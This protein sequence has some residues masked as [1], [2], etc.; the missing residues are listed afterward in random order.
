M[1]PRPPRRL[2]VEYLENPLGVDRRAPRFSWVDEHAGRAQSQTA[3]QILVCSSQDLYAARRGDLWDSGK[4]MSDATAHIE[5]RGA[6]LRSHRR[7]S[8]GVRWWDRDGEPSPFS[9]TAFFDTGLLEAREW[10]AR[11]ITAKKCPKFRSRGSVFMGEYRGDYAQ[12]HAVYLRKEILLKKPVRRALAFVCGLGF[13][14]LRV[15]GKRVGTSVLEPAQT[16]YR[17]RALYATHDVTE[18]LERENAIG[19]VLGNG[20]YIESYGYGRPRGIL[21][22]EVE[23]ADGEEATFVTDATWRTSAGPLRENGLYFGEVYDARVEMPGWDR[24][25]FN[26]SGW[27]AAV[28]VGGSPLFSQLMPPIRV[29]ERLRPRRMLSPERGVYVFDFGQNFAGWV[30]LHVRGPRG[31]EVRLRHAELVND[32]GTLNVSPNQNAPATDVYVLNGEGLETYEPRFT[33][34]GF[35]FVEV[36]GF[37]GVPVLDSVEGCVVH[38]DVERTGQFSCSEPL[39]QRIHENVLWGQRANLMSIPTDC[40]QRDER[41]GWLGD[42]HLVA[43]QAILNF[44]MA[45]FYT[46][47]LADIREAQREDGALPDVVPCYIKE[48]YPGDPAWATAYVTIAWLVYLYYG[49]RSVLRDHY[50]SLKG[51]VEFLR[52]QAEGHIQRKLGKYGDWCPPG[53]I[54][55]KRT[56]VELTSTWC[57]YHDVLVLSRIAA[58]LDERAD[59]AAYAKLAREIEAAF[60]RAFL[61]KDQYLARTFSP[62]DGFPSQTSNVLPLALG[63]VPEAKREKVL[64]RLIH[65]VVSDHDHHL[66]TGILGTRYLL[67]VLQLNGH[68]DVAYRIATQ[69]TYPSWGYMVEEGATTLWERWEKVAGGGMNS[70]NHI[71]LGSIDAWFYK[72]LAGIRVLEPGWRKVHVKVPALE[73]L[74]FAAASLETMRGRFQ[75]SWQRSKSNLLVALEV[76]VGTEALL[77]VPILRDVVEL[78]EQG[79]LLWPSRKRGSPLPRVKQRKGRLTITCPSGF[80][81]FELVSDE[82]W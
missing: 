62:V 9:S 2:R 61:G 73:K 58:V 8:W 76:P 81:L 51:Y 67:E 21:Q 68:A 30:R 39:L 72:A 11:W 19:L 56:P 71:M 6:A 45:A 31:T 38:T 3:Y 63:M 14:D 44:D 37:P 4:M 25:G 33:Y 10:K 5:Y 12:H 24:C 41:Y 35:R 50:P 74:E 42:A 22:L 57:A 69:R 16:D 65:N 1:T 20:R 26:D 46:K 82:R 40:P 60:N 17:K 64:K 48:L 15:N 59:H 54:T 53:S 27:G 78:R 36:T 77:E 55:P 13:H 49:D 75:A 79:D 28:V 66:D 80:Y 70:H 29:T 52:S 18:R 32:D 23:Y 47:F 43:E 7:Y 34:H